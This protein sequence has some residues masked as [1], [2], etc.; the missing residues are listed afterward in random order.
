MTGP[1]H[2]IHHVSIVVRDI[3]RAMAWYESVGIGPWSEF[4]AG[5]FAGLPLLEVPDP[6]AFAA[7]KYRYVNLDNI[8]LQLCEPP[9]GLDSPQKRFLD[10][11][12]E[13]VYV[14]AFENPWEE[15]AAA[16][17]ALGLPVLQRGRR[18]NGSG[19]IYFDT[20]EEAGVVL[21]AR[22]S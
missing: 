16:G 8:Q 5:A 19:F 22:Q 2:R 17:E 7:M 3:E 4:P 15:T 9:A 18:E 11:H 10:K 14:L 13:G 21:M 1:F 12:G 6:E 20:L